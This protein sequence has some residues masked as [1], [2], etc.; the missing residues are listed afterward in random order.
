[1]PRRRSEGPRPGRQRPLSSVAKGTIP[2]WAA[3]RERFMPVTAGTHSGR[4]SPLVWQA[5]QHWLQPL[6]SLLDCK[7]TGHEPYP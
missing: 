1:M 2:V 7:R 4:L 6:S 3:R 5:S